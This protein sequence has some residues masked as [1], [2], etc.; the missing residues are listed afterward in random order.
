MF[1]Y[2]GINKQV[3]AFVAWVL[4]RTRITVS[5]WYRVFWGSWSLIL[6]QKKKA[7]VRSFAFTEDWKWVR[8]VSGCRQPAWK[9]LSGIRWGENR[10]F[11]DRVGCGFGLFQTLNANKT[12][13]RLRSSDSPHSARL[14]GNTP[15]HGC[16][17]PW[18]TSVPQVHRLSLLARSY[19]LGF[20]FFFSLFCS[21]CHPLW[22][23]WLFSLEWFDPWLWCQGG[24]VKWLL[25]IMSQR[26]KIP[27]RPEDVEGLMTLSPLLLKW[28]SSCWTGHF[29]LMDLFI[30]FHQ[31]FRCHKSQVYLY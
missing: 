31:V 6:V 1:S 13:Q 17:V 25:R 11:C 10:T 18:K 14:M 16:C 24:C 19:F 28:Q 15:L 8:W 4:P 7:D 26:R 27:V 22:E 2:S 20:P 9:S 23:L 30:Y 12:L 3:E 5:I 21:T 29:P